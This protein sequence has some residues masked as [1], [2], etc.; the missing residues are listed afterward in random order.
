MMGDFERDRKSIIFRAIFRIS[1]TIIRPDGLRCAYSLVLNEFRRLTAPLGRK[2]IASVVNGG[3]VLN[4]WVAGLIFL[5]VL[6]TALKIPRYSTLPLDLVGII[7][8]KVAPSNSVCLIRRTYPSKTDD[9]FQ[10]GQ[11][12]F[13]FAEIRE[14]HPDGVIIQNLVTNNLEYLTFQ[15]NK[16]LAKH[17]PPPP[18]PRVM[19][20]SS[21]TVNI[22]LP[23]NTINH[24]LENLP[25]LLASAV[26]APRY[27][28]DKN[29]QKIIDGFEIS[30][31]KEGSVVERL[32]LKNGDV[33]LAVNGEPLDSLAT[34]MRLL[35]GIKNMSEA[36]LAVLRDGRK[37]NFVFNKK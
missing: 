21:D 5:G 36:K 17:P 22:D 13:D 8:N 20:K 10:P 15:K 1:G 27:R 29:G 32:D 4:K 11:K 19:T 35:G 7:V 26:A 28:E 37:L 6:P 33:I 14:I 25:D 12:A 34:V 18:T 30:R 2:Y 24:Y 9:A 31:I 23:K 16:P 3:K